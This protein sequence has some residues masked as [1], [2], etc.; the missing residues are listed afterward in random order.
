VRRWMGM[1]MLHRRAIGGPHRFYIV[2]PRDLSI[3]AIAWWR[4]RG[5]SGES[6]RVRR[7]PVPLRPGRVCAALAVPVVRGQGRLG[8]RQLAWSCTRARMELTLDHEL[9]GT[10]PTSEVWTLCCGVLDRL[11]RNGNR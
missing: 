1:H 11:L 3:A 4:A 10:D 2:S 5:D 8:S 7:G 6:V 9:D